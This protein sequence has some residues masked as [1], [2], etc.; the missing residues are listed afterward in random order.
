MR[1]IESRDT[2]FFREFEQDTV[3]AASDYAALR[4][5]L[6]YPTVSVGD[7]EYLVHCLKYLES[8]M[9]EYREPL[10]IGEQTLLPS[11]VL[12]EHFSQGYSRIN[13]GQFI[14]VVPDEVAAKL[15]AE[16]IVYAAMTQAPVSQTDFAALH[17]LRNERSSK[18]FNNDYYDMVNSLANVRREN[19]TINAIF[20]FPLFYL[21][22]VLTMVSATILT[23]QLL[24]D[25]NRYRRQYALLNNLGMA[26]EEMNR[27]L[28]RKF[29]LFYAMP[30][31]PPVA[32]CLIFMSWMGT[33]FD[34]GTIV[35]LWHLWG[36]IGLALGFFFTIYLIYI[37]ASFSSFKRN[38][39]PE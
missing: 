11:G 21:A 37:A 3:L 24:S 16:T 17:A 31:I 9:A 34:A 5:L 8:H 14:L 19:A 20:V 15:E 29:T 23:I 32:I 22:L 26:R 4:R 39:L 13:G 18:F 10:T 1:Y 27:A 33:L 6:G 7:G 12:T 36:M 38:V 28:R 25:T 35:S 2:G 30:T